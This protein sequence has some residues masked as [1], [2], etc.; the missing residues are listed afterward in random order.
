MTFPQASRFAGNHD[1]VLVGYRGVDGSVR[2]D[3]PEVSAAL[4]GTSDLLAKK[5]LQ[6]Y[7]GAFRSCAARLTGDGVNLARLQPR[8]TRR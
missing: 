7:S 3:C 6:A 2:L 4:T 5:T 8:R 1:V